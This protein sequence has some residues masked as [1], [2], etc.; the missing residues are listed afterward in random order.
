MKTDEWPVRVTV[1]EPEHRREFNVPWGVWKE[2]DEATH[3]LKLTRE[4]AFGLAAKLLIAE[5]EREEKEDTED[6]EQA[7]VTFI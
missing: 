1:E 5:A 6:P 4:K 3:R 7:S 2:F